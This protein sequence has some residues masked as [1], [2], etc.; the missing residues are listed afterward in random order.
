MGPEKL[1]DDDSFVCFHQLFP[2]AAAAEAADL[3]SGGGAIRR[4]S[5]L[6]WQVPMESTDRHMLLKTK[7]KINST[8]PFAV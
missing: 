6:R 2:A 5:L 8:A 7:A 3:S 1:P 4:R